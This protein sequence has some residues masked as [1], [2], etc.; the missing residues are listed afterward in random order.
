[1]AINKAEGEVVI[2]DAGNYEI[3]LNVRDGE[4]GMGSAAVEVVVGNTAPVVTFLLPKDGDFFEPGEEISYALKIED[5]ED[6]TSEGG[7]KASMMGGMTMVTSQWIDDDKFK[8]DS[9]VGMALMKQSDCFNCHAMDQKIVGPTLLEIAGRYRGQ[10]GAP[11]ASAERVLKG[12]A[13]VWGEIPMLPHPQHMKDGI[14]MMLE[15][16]FGLKKGGGGVGIHRGTEGVVESPK[17]NKV[18]SGVLVAEFTDSGNS[19]AKPLTAVAR[20]SV[21]KRTLEAE[22]GDEL[23]KAKGVKAP[24]ATGNRALGR[25]GRNSA[26]KVGNVYLGTIASVTMRYST[27]DG[28]RK[29]AIRKGGVEGPEIGNF[30]LA[31]GGEWKD[32]EARI[33]KED[34]IADLYFVFD[35][36]MMVDWIRFNK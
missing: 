35:G 26:V 6:G 30:D 3:L 8:M 5:V 11:D 4:G 32:A 16:I 29:V 7:A 36:P 33:G 12:S 21:R 31:G 14:H 1:M 2:G 15:W 34:G 19:P 23:I 22:E 13:G 9:A 24:G 17:G 27:G 20:V 25:V 10:K 28:S 18:R